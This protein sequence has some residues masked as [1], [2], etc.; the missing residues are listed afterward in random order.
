MNI[1]FTPPPKLQRRLERA[2][3]DTGISQQELS[4]DTGDNKP[5]IVVLDRSL[6]IADDRVTAVDRAGANMPGDDLTAAGDG[7]AADKD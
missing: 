4:E 6:D 2:E 5:P 3:E 1:S 7:M